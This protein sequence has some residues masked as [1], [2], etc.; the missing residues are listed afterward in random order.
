MTRRITRLAVL[1]ALVL[2]AVLLFGQNLTARGK[3]VEIDMVARQYEY[4]PSEIV[5]QQGDTVRINLDAEDVTHG[6]DPPAPV[7]SLPDYSA[8]TIFLV[9]VLSCV[10][11]R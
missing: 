5:V 4:S 1:A 11:S 3:V 2:C 8:T 9:I 7:L 6:W 10:S